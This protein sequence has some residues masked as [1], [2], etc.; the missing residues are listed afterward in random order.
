MLTIMFTIIAII[1]I[2][3][4]SYSIYRIIKEGSQDACQINSD[5]INIDSKNYTNILKEVHDNLDKYLGKK[6]RFSG[7]IYKVPDFSDMQF[8][9]ARD[10]II[11]SDLKTL[12]VG[13]LC[14]C[15]E[16]KNFEE[17]TW[18]EIVGT[19][20]KGNYHEPIPVINVSEIKKVVKP[21]ECYVYPPDSSFV[22]TVNLF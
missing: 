14:N 20:E 7:Y 17:N 21:T 10:M 13:F 15:K 2:C 8:V 1:L 6:I 19:I 9:L 12:V 22:P 18:V 16:A 11:S 5:V 4:F 3:F